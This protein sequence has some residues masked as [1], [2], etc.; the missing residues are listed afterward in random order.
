MN[1]VTRPGPAVFGAHLDQSTW[2]GFNVIH[3]Y[4][5]EECEALLHGRCIIVNVRSSVLTYFF[6]EIFANIRLIR[7][8]VQSRQC[9]NTHS[10]LLTLALYL[11]QISLFVPTDGSLKFENRWAFDLI[12]LSTNGIISSPK[13]PT[14]FWYSNNST[15]LAMPGHAH[16]P[17]SLTLSMR[18]QSPERALKLGRFSSGLMRRRLL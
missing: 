15:T 9:T 12:L 5:P 14:K 11:I 16:I 7:H 4:F 17:H 2:Q 3:K 6:W 10:G 1:Q 13:R 18:M 8:G